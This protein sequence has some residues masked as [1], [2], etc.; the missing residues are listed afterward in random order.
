VT[1][2]TEVG[3]VH[4]SVMSTKFSTDPEKVSKIPEFKVEIFQS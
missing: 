2:H 4:L 1:H 3:Q